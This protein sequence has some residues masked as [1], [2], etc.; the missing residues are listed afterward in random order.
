MQGTTLA[1]GTEKHPDTNWNAIDWHQED[2]R[3]RNLRRRIFRATQAGDWKRVRS[4]QKLMLRSRANR[5]TSVR[6]VAQLNAGK[7]TPGVDKVLLK[8]PAARGRMVDHLAHYKLWTA[9]PT[10]RVYIAKAN[11]KLRPLGIP[12]MID[13]CVQSMVKN[14][15]EPSWEARFEGCSYGFR[16]GR[17]CHDAIEKIYRLACPNRRKKWIVDADIKGAFD[18]ISHDYLLTTI[19]KVPGSE[20]IKQWLKAGYVDKGVFRETEAGTPQGGVISPLLANIALHGMEEALGIKHKK[21][22]EL[23]SKRAI[24]RYAD[25]FCVFCE[26]QEDAEVSKHIL[27]EWLSKRG[28]VL[29][30]EKTQIVHLTEGFD[31]LSFNIR[32]Y[33]A[34]NTKTGWKLLTKPSKEAVQKHREKMK[35]EWKAVRGWNIGKI[36]WKLNPI[37]RGWSNYQRT[38]TAKETFNKLDDWMFY[39]EVRHVKRTHP[40]KPKKWQQ[41][42]YWGRLNLDR[43][44]HWVFGDKQT[45]Q[46]LLKYCWFPIERHIL[47]KGTASPD[48]PALKDYWQKR[49]AAKAKDLPPSRQKIA[50]K[51]HGVCLECHTT[52]FNDEE[53]HVHHRVPKARG[54]KNNYGNLVLVHYF[55]HQQIHARED[56]KDELS[57]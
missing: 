21:R 5:L 47:V 45:G 27:T 17:G 33:R 41:R 37:I 29:S 23:D 1:N 34:S 57:E 24:V 18:N 7:N 14:A 3:V 48:D 38:G 2:Q 35:Q 56:V 8:T 4:L 19:G 22:G 16:P 6:R 31:F 32:L 15:L 40:H 44:D 11:G 46:H 50:R 25:D 52:L 39:K 20:L 43:Q 9:K 36:L 13:R 51:Q 49:N 12:V 26:S 28:L 53:L 30:P 42:K 10:R 54:G 55:C